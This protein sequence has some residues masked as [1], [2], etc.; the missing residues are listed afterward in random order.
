MIFFFFSLWERRFGEWWNKKN[1]L[2]LLWSYQKHPKLLQCRGSCGKLVWN[3]CGKR[4]I[5]LKF[6]LTGEEL[7]SLKAQCVWSFTDINW[8]TPINLSGTTPFYGLTHQSNL[9]LLFIF[10]SFCFL[11]QSYKNKT[12]VHLRN[13]LG[14]ETHS[15]FTFLAGTYSLFKKMKGIFYW[16]FQNLENLP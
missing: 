14:E 7:Y 2:Q 12:T 10:Q 8:W 6:D 5:S 11:K 4:L 16:Q 15:C 3:R 1:A 13:L 9:S